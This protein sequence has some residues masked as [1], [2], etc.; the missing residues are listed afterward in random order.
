MVTLNQIRASNSI[1]GTSL[2]PGLVAVFA[3]ATSGIGEATLK[4]FVKHAVKPRIYFLGRSK[5]SGDRVRA[6]LQKINPEG[7]YNFISVDVSL[8]RS[9]DD[10]CREIGAKESAINLLFL[11]TGTIVRGNETAE[12]LH[13]FAAVA[14]YARMRF[15]VNLLPLLQRATGLRRVVTV[16]AGTKEGLVDAGDMQG[17]RASVR[18]LRGHVASLATLALEAVAARRAPGVAFVHDYPG[19]VQTPLGQ[20]DATGL[21]AVVLAAANAVLGLLAPLI[22]VPLDESGERHLFLATSARFPPRD[23]NGDGGGSESGGGDGSGVPLPAGVAVARGTDGETGSGVYSVDQDAESAPA[24]VERLLDGLRK[25]G[26][27]EKVWTDLET[28]FVRITGA[29]SI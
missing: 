7:E 5:G 18:A 6:E 24:K 29:T 20:R 19:Y 4:Q 17:R 16:A 8:L 11:S 28:E 12:G 15:V 25:D 10:V 9:V 22:A 13:Y 26:T 2:G 3:G 21:T 14:Y 23:I 1:V 27:A